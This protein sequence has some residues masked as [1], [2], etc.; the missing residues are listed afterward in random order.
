MQTVIISSVL[1]LIAVL[2]AILIYNVI[3]DETEDIHAAAHAISDITLFTGE[4]ES[5]ECA[6][7]EI[8][9][10][11]GECEEEIINRVVAIKGL[12]SKG[13]Y[14]CAVIVT[15]DSEEAED[16]VKCWGGG[17]SGAIPSSIP[18]L[19]NIG[20][21]SVSPTHRCAIID[22]DMSDGSDNTLKCWGRNSRKQLGWDSGGYSTSRVTPV[23]GIVG[24]Q[25][26]STN[27]YN[28]CVIIFE[29]SL[30]G[31][32]K[33]VKCWG[34]NSR[35]QLGTDLAGSY[36]GF[37]PRTI[38]QLTG[39][40]I[41]AV[42]VGALHI[43]V[44]IGGSSSDGSADT[45]WCWGDNAHSQLGD[46]AVLQKE[47]TVPIEITGLTEVGLTE[48]KAISA[49]D[50]NT[51]AIIGRSNSDSSDDIVK[52]WGRG[53]TYELLD[54]SAPENKPTPI[55]IPGSRGAKSLALGPY[56]VCII[57]SA[58][59]YRCVGYVA[60]DG[61][62]DGAGQPAVSFIAAGREH[63]CM[64]YADNSIKCFGDNSRAQIG[65]TP[66]MGNSENHIPRVVPGTSGAKRVSVSYGTGCFITSSD[67]L[68]CWGSNRNG[69]LGLFNIAYE[70][71][72]DIPV[73]ISGLT[74][75]VDIDVVYNASCAVASRS[76]QNSDKAVKCWGSNGYNQLGRDS[77]MLN[78]LK[79]WLGHR[80]G[81]YPSSG[82]SALP[83]SV[84]E[85]LDPK[86][87]VLGSKHACA[88]VGADGVPDGSADTVWCWGD[89]RLTQVEIEF[90]EYYDVARDRFGEWTPRAP[91]MRPGP[92]GVKAI[93]AGDEHT[94]AIAAVLDTTT[95]K[96]TGKDTV[97]CWGHNI[98]GAV[99]TRS[100]GYGQQAM[101]IPELTGAKAVATGFYHTCAITAEDTVKCWAERNEYGQLGTDPFDRPD[102]S[103]IS[104]I[105]VPGLK[106]VTAISIGE[107]ATTCAIAAVLDTT[108][109]E[110][111]SEDAI[112]C[113]GRNSRGM[114]GAPYS[115]GV[116]SES[117]EYSAAPVR[118]QGIT[119]PKG[120]DVGSQAACA[121][122]AV[123]D[124]ATGE[125]TSEDAVYCWGA[126][127]SAEFIPGTDSR[128]NYFSFPQ[129]IRG[130]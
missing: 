62:E 7:G 92:V 84:E 109:G 71:S 117:V 54:D 17:S 63:V 23:P 55:E 114:I 113:W 98:Y 78:I 43:C 128:L 122:V 107:P 52:C 8:R 101:P 9:N 42:A 15:S 37:G 34:V 93:S 79:L 57:T 31:N 86:A 29:P 104:F 99:G 88:I 125:P 56:T 2:A 65:R 102:D 73:K 25:D 20:T 59:S 119:N 70:N 32:G 47:S 72:T 124:V 22:G 5:E 48:V 110:P 11:L 1:A 35:G 85:V 36:T 49:G 66:I 130:L 19:E 108:T 58:D 33:S 69:K 61:S 112:Y 44:I 111:T 100:G 67:T 89:N 106:R 50:A 90:Q 115:F 18:G 87:V 127:N 96:P 40:D 39:K 105:D 118:I 12:H 91:V 68:E 76:A 46:N 126:I 16:T 120:I 116:P 94:C 64:A 41:K 103:S 123:L 3:S 60:R 38:E 13:D 74:G 14:T 6:I 51:C 28:T 82:S 97:W 45:V 121:V 80:E 27:Y 26:V 81:P 95:G 24:V 83:I 21:L 75:V 129:R 77:S 53:D 4:A 10:E 30:S